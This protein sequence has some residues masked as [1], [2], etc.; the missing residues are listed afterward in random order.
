MQDAAIRKST[1]GRIDSLDVLRGFAVLGILVMNIQAFAMVSAAY[2]NPN[3]LGPITGPEWWVWLIGHLFFD[4]KFLAIFA[5][6]FGAG[7]VLMAERAGLHGVSPVRRHVRRMLTLAVIGALHAYAVW[8]GDILLIY[9][10]VGVVAFLFRK[11]PV[12]RLLLF[13]AMFYLIPVLWMLLMTGMLQLMP[14]ASYQE[15]ADLYWQ[16]TADVLAAQQAAYQ[17]GW[18]AQMQQR[19]PDALTMH[20]MV[21]PTEE[22]WRVLALM[23]AG[24][25]AYKSG[26]LSAAWSTRRYQR[27]MVIGL[28]VGL[29][30]VVAGVLH[31]QL[32]GWEMGRAMFLGVMF[33]HLATP[34]IALAWICG[35]L[36]VLKRGWLP[37][38]T[39]RLQA[40][41]RAAL[42]AYLL[43]SVL[44]TLVFYGHGLGLFGQ[45]DRM[46]QLL[47]VGAV[48]ALLLSVAPAWFRR[49][50]MG[51]VEWMWRWSV[52]GEQP[53]L[54]RI[55]V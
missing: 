23:L 28:L 26:L 41:G 31:N 35:A 49:F 15:M 47:V 38:L 45:L 50:R 46:E 14:E 40:V 17:G 4:G 43:T 7:L 48:W 32:V 34:F 29:P 11:L 52:Y 9:A 3:A 5:A 53:R 51:P 25:A 12:R 8:Y 22:A 33:N 42:S 1:Q 10:L 20:L 27:L 21:F 54:R 13:A 2:I 55:A 16:P 36:V 39:A 24:M 37:G 30:I 18:L 6:L 19:V 44:C